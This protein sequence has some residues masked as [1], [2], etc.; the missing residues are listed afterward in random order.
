MV[1]IGGDTAQELIV[2][3]MKLNPPEKPTWAL[4]EMTVMFGHT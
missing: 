1:I 3:G 2:L 4:S